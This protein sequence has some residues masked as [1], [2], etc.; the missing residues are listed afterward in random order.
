MT[1]TPR[2]RT[3]LLL[4]V[5]ALLMPLVPAAAGEIQPLE[6][7]TWAQI[8]EAHKGRPLIVHLWGVTCAPCRTEMPEWGKLAQR[9]PSAGIVILHAERMPPDPK[10]V[11][12][13]LD[14]AG[15]SNADTWAFAET[16]LA[17]L[18]YEI[19]P[20]WLGELPMT[21]L[22]DSDGRRKTI[23]GAADMAEVESWIAAQ[24]KA[25]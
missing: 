23:I 18:R 4:A 1:M 7:G 8:L 11:R 5:L 10:I 3:T 12:E 2:I 13:M 22:I 24:K 15:L 16:M 25:P 6:R 20:K 9:H 17:R 19:D 21:L 14:D